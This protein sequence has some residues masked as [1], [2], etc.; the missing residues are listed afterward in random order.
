MKRQGRSRS[1]EPTY[2]RMAELAHIMM[3]LEMLAHTERR[4]QSTMGE[5]IWMK[6][7]KGL[8][9]WGLEREGVAFLRS[10]CWLVARISK[11]EKVGHTKAENNRV[12]H[13]AGLISGHLTASTK[14]QPEPILAAEREGTR[15]A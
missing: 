8:E 4:H 13:P 12:Q 7:K 5:R 1:E 9:M 11:A 14:E 15:Q 6:M 2:G 10:C 3:G